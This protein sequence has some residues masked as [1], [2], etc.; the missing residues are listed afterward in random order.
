MSTAVGSTVE[1]KVL[2][3]AEQR[4]LTEIESGLRTDD[5]SFV[6]RFETTGRGRHRRRSIGALLA[7]VA[8]LTGT[9]VG[10]VGGSVAVAILGV[11]AIGAAIGVWAIRYD[12]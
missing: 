10:L 3:D 4:R 7:I 2:S 11:T 5:P 1:V 6:Q 8:A 9:V 12:T